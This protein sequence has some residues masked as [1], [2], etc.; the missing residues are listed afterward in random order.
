MGAPRLTNQPKTLA[1]SEETRRKDRKQKA[2]V[3]R[4]A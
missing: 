2:K 1:P 4:R 3:Q